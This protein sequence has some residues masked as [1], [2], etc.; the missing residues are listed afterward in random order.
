MGAKPFGKRQEVSNPGILT[1]YTST[2]EARKNAALKLQV[3]KLAVQVAALEARLASKTGS[4]AD[5][6]AVAEEARPSMEELVSSLNELAAVAAEDT[7][8][9]TATTSREYGSG[10]QPRSTL[11]RAPGDSASMVSWSADAFGKSKTPGWYH[12]ARKG[13]YKQRLADY[14]AEPTG[15]YI[16]HSKY[17]DEAVRI[18]N[19]G[20]LAF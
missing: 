19:T 5:G 6:L 15:S 1:R 16:S 20:R 18:A 7:T 17:A 11:Y 9:A 4:V 12:T 3:E 14:A 2:H 8:P 13:L 10:P